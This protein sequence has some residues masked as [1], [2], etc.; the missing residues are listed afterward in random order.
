[1]GSY[2]TISVPVKRHIS[3]FIISTEGNPFRIA[4]E[5]FVWKLIRPY[6]VYKVPAGWHRHADF[7]KLYPA[8]I[9]LQLPISKMCVYGLHVGNSETAMINNVLSDY[10]S[11]QLYYFVELNSSASGRYRGINLAIN[12]FCQLHGIIID[13][14]IS[15]DALQKIFSRRKKNFKKNYG[16]CRSP[17]L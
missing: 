10:F 12:H 14:D 2:Y 11:F 3:K 8:H 16:N 7:Y 4:K 13:E 5:N 17:L 6:M 1:M 15:I 9:K